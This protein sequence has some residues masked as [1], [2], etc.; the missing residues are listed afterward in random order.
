MSKWDKGSIWGN[1]SLCLKKLQQKNSSLFKDYLKECLTFLL[2]IHSQ[3]EVGKYAFEAGF[4]FLYMQFIYIALF[5]VL[6]LK[7]L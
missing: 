2:S 3:T 1:K 6:T 7:G 5:G 4:F